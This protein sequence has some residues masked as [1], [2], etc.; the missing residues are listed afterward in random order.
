MSALHAAADAAHVKR[1]LDELG[2]EYIEP[3]GDEQATAALMEAFATFV[4]D[5]QP[6]QSLAVLEENHDGSVGE[7]QGGGEHAIYRVEINDDDE[8]VVSRLLR[9][10]GHGLTVKCIRRHM[11]MCQDIERLENFMLVLAFGPTTGQIRHIDAM[12][13]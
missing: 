12:V 7:L 11:L 3:A 5:E 9:A 2:V 10:H 4:L 8:S 1:E 6:Q 13:A